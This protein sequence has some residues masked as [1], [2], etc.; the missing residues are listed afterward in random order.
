MVKKSPHPYE[1]GLCIKAG[2]W[3]ALMESI[4]VHFKGNKNENWCLLLSI[5]KGVSWRSAL[6]EDSSSLWAGVLNRIKRSYSGCAHNMTSYFILSQTY[7]PAIIDCIPKPGANINP[8]LHWFCQ[9][10]F[11][12]RTI[13][14]TVTWLSLCPIYFPWTR[15]HLLYKISLHQERWP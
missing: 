8:C 10:F 7:L 15:T 9:I 2:F 3:N 1:H 5:C 13:K 4:H 11:F 6:N 14:S 12:I